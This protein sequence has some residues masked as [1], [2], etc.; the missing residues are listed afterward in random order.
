KWSVVV[1]QAPA[2]AGNHRHAVQPT[3]SPFLQPLLDARVGNLRIQPTEQ[4]AGFCLVPRVVDR[5]VLEE[6]QTFTTVVGVNEAPGVR[7][8]SANDAGKLS[9]LHAV[10]LFTLLGYASTDA[11]QPSLFT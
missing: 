3:V 8:G 1:R 7:A 11:Q 9:P 5:L 2:G 10:L 4:L 6:F